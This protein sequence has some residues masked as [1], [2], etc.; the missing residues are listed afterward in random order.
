MPG[1]A[2]AVVSPAESLAAALAAAAASGQQPWPATGHHQ[3]S[4]DMLSRWMALARPNAAAAGP[5][6]AGVAPPAAQAAAQPPVPSPQIAQQPNAAT[7]AVAGASDPNGFYSPMLMAMFEQM[8]KGTQRSPVVQPPNSPPAVHR[9]TADKY[10]VVRELVLTGGELQ[11]AVES[12]PVDALDEAYAVLQHIKS[13]GRHDSEL[14]QVAVL[15]KDVCVWA[16]PSSRHPS[17]WL[18]VQA[19]AGELHMLTSRGRSGCGLVGGSP[20]PTRR[21]GGGPPHHFH[22]PVPSHGGRPNGMAGGSSLPPLRGAGGIGGGGAFRAVGGS[23][24]HDRSSHKAEAAGSPSSSGHHEHHHAQ[25]QQPQHGGRPGSRLAGGSYSNSEGA[26]QGSGNNPRTL[27]EAVDAAARSGDS[28]EA[29]DYS[30]NRSY[31]HHH[32]DQQQHHQAGASKGAASPGQAAGREGKAAGG[33]ADAD[34]QE[35]EI[36]ALVGI[37]ALS[38]S[39]KGEA[40]EHGT[41]PS[42]DGTRAY[43]TSSDDEF[44]ALKNPPKRR[45][46]TYQLPA[47]AA[48]ASAVPAVA[49]APA[50]AP[51]VPAPA[52]APAT[53]AGSASAGDAAQVPAF[54]GSADAPATAAADNSADQLV[55][56]AHERATSVPP[57]AAITDLSSAAAG[58][59]QEAAT[60]A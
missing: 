56:V 39:V 46:S 21:A 38:K 33:K 26:K 13:R 32:E 35:E 28:P 40:D 8:L 4:T 19:S 29:S 15:H 25:Q 54:A 14:E 12:G 55:A 43:L 20:E 49:A 58:I 2:G 27:A 6:G 17:G 57:P 34:M 36:D 44:N 50:T 52:T 16:E 7:T 31:H 10:Y 3:P 45:R 11:V 41:P 47:A 9:G 23:P 1:L 60:V 59:V 53:A 42:S 48:A 22:R 51:H 18:V 30:V 37:M 5:L 24:V